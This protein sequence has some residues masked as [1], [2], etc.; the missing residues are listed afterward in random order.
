MTGTAGDSTVELSTDTYT[1]VESRV[2]RSEFDDVSEYVEF[3]LDS[4]LDE[5]EGGSDSSDDDEEVRDRLR[6]L[7]Y[8]E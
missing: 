5:L 8:L 7:G 1:R 3:V 6:E 4:L 2:E